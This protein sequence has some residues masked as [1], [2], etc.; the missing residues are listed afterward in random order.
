[1][2]YYTNTIDS[3]CGPLL[4]VV[5]AEGAVIRIEFNDA[6]ELVAKPTAKLSASASK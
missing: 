4:C 5:N 6:G 1:M 2:T 3:P